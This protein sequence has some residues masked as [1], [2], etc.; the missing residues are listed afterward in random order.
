VNIW[1]TAGPLFFMLGGGVRWSLADNL[2]LTGAIR[3]NFAVMP[4]FMPTVGP[5]IGLQLGL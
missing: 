3:A 5:E 1:R 4:V 2:A